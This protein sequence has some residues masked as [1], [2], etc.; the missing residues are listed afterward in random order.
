MDPLLAGR[1]MI[2]IFG[3]LIQ[4]YGQGKG[5]GYGADTFRVPCEREIR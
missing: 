3:Q 4:I 1:Q 5:F 2:R